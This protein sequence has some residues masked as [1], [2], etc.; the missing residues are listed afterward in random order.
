MLSNFL[1]DYFTFSRRERSGIIVLIAIMLILVIANI[2]V[3]LVIDYQ[4]YDYSDYETE[5]LYF[6][7]SVKSGEVKKENEDKPG[8]LF[9]FNPNTANESELAELGFDRRVIRNIIKYRE[10][11]GCFYRKKDF[12]KIYGID[13]PAYKRLA[14]FIYLETEGLRKVSAEEKNNDN[15]VVVHKPI[16]INRAEAS[17]LKD[18]LGVDRELSE[19]IIKYRYLLGGFSDKKQFCE[20][21]GITRGQSVYLAENVFIDTALI[22]KININNANEQALSRHP[23]INDYYARA[24]VKYRKFS[25]KIIKINELLINNILPEEVYMQISSYLTAD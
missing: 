20:I 8:R 6:E 10:H 17:L 21:Y 4:D 7:N 25:G 1:K 24:I 2:I 18:T 11:G 23:Y 19:R 14:P 15:T 16:N 12:L 9:M 13:T 22:R 5:L 3:P